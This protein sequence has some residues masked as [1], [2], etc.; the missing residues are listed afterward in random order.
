MTKKK[1][2]EFSF[3][4]SEKEEVVSN[5][6]KSS[7]IKFNRWEVI[8]KFK[9]NKAVYLP[10]ELDLPLNIVLPENLAKLLTSKK[11]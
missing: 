4:T 9:M 5:E 2:K 7:D 11:S 8:S 3:L 10:W 6:K 1:S